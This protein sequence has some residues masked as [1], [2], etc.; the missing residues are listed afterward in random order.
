MSGP[1]TVNAS[2]DSHLMGVYSRT[3]L[4]FERGEGVRLFGNDG[5][6]YLDCVAGIACIEQSCVPVSELA[7]SDDRTT[8]IGP[9]GTTLCAPYRCD[10]E[11]GVCATSCDASRDCASGYVCDSRQRACVAE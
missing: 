8:S 3:P 10:D 2:T 6:T 9:T 11:R 7:C 1:A 4:A 5:K